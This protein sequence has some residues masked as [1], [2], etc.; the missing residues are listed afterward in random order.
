MII[1]GLLHG[2][3]LQLI[4]SLGNYF[5]CFPMIM[6]DENFRK[7]V[8]AEFEQLKKYIAEF[9]DFLDEGERKSQANIPDSNEALPQINTDL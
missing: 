8:R 4:G 6:S 9:E 1:D 3:I 7:D 5:A 2:A